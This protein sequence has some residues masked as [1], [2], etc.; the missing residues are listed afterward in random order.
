MRPLS[1]AEAIQPAIHRTRAVLFQ[2]FKPGR[3]WKLAAIA[4]LSAMGSYFLPMPYLSFSSGLSRSGP[5]Q[6]LIAI[7]LGLLFSAVMF[8][9]FYFGARLEFVLFDIVLLNEKFIAPSWRRHRHHSWRWI[10]FKAIFSALLAVACG[11][12]FYVAYLYL[13]PR[14]QAN[15]VLPGQP[16]P[17]ELFKYLFLF[18]AAIG[19]PAALAVFA[20]SLLT[21]FVLPSIALEDLTVRQG[22]KRFF[23][24]IKIE[25]GPLALFAVLKL[26]LGVAGLIAMEAC[27]LIAELL[28]LIPIGLVALAG[29][30]LLRSAG[31]AGHVVMLAGAVL[32]LLAFM[33][34]MGYG[35]FLFMGTLHVFFQAYALYFLGGRYPMLGEL[36]E[37]SL[38]PLPVPIEPPPQP[39]PPPPF[40]AGPPQEPA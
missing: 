5:P 15:T 26:V 11:P 4:Y 3:T 38:P 27:I 19:I 7:G 8:V 2:P 30:F 16:P 13:L 40:A 25:P 39:I 21:N 33:V 31:S 35:L 14:L 34:A 17:P 12:L 22:L 6:T 29:W 24:L 37:P 20:S 1:A 18:Y 9:F 10:G 28:C 36:L 32:L 23:D